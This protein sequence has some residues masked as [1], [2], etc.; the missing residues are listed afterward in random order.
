[1]YRRESPGQTKLEFPYNVELNPCSKWI[2]LADLIPWDRIEEEYAKHFPGYEGQIAKPARLAFGAV[3]I[4][5]SEGFTDGKTREHIMENPHMQY[6]CGFASYGAI[7][8]FDASM[9]VHFRKRIPMEMIKQITEEVFGPEALKEMDA[10]DEEVLGETEE[11]PNEEEL[12]GSEETPKE[13]AVKKAEATADDTPANGNRG[14]LILDATCCPQDIKYPTD[15]GLLNHARELSEEII[16]KLY[17]TVANQYAYKPR[18]YRIVARKDYLS[19]AKTR[20]HTKK[21]IRKQ[22][23]KQLQ[24]LA[25][26]L[27]IIKDLV[28]KGASLSTLS[29]QLYKKLLVIGEVFRQ[30][31]EMYDTKTNRCDGRIVSIAQP[32]VRPIVRGKE[33]DP[34]EFGSKVAIGLVGGY[35]F[36]TD[37]SW[38]NIAE[39]SLLPQAAEGYKSMFGF[40]PKNI[41]GDKIYPNRSNRQYCKEHGIRLSGPKLGRKN[42]ETKREESKQRYQDGCERNAIEGEFGTTKRKLGLALVMTKLPEASETMIAMGFFVANMERKLRLLFVSNLFCFIIYDFQEISLVFVEDYPQAS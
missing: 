13:E 9:M 40:Y 20:K 37:I 15:T 11:V 3:Y 24:Y 36:I 16:D 18:T 30:Q 7:P 26:N 22:I 23:R 28:A 21:Q 35:A 4:Q 12:S 31:K 19:Y 10:P 41:I 34:T 29:R 27:H 1:M 42:E 17:K 5:A 14:T 8:P 25:R 33:H 39:A 38:K 32:H 6:F 2:I